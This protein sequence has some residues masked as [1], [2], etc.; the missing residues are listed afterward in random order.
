MIYFFICVLVIVS[1]LCDGETQYVKV[2]VY[3]PR[4]RP[5]FFNPHGTTNDP[6]FQHGTTY[7]LISGTKMTPIFPYMVQNH[8]RLFG[9]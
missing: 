6:P 9:A 8:E 3:A 5:P 4:E 1:K 2:Y 7:D